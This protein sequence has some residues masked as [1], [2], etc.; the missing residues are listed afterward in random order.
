MLQR[1]AMS[2]AQVQT[3]G[4][5]V[6]VVM[7][8]RPAEGKTIHTLHILEEIAKNSPDPKALEHILISR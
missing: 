7:I 3:E 1:N 2:S 5:E 8:G 6:G 4:E